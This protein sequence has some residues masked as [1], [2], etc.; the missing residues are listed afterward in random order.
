MFTSMESPTSLLAASLLA[1]SSWLVIGALGLAPA[2]DFPLV[3][4]SFNL[5]YSGH[6]L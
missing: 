1:A 3:N 5:S 6:D 4:K 2:G